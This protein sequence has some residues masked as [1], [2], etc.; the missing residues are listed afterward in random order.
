MA[1][2]KINL[3]NINGLCEF[4]VFILTF[5]LNEKKIILDFFHFKFYEPTM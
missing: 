4:H 3:D 5:F 2:G 1:F